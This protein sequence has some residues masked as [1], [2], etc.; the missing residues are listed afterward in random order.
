MPSRLEDD[1]ADEGGSDG[2]RVEVGAAL[3]AVGGVGMEEMAF[4]A[5]A[6]SA[7]VEPGSFHED[8]F[9]VAEM[10]GIEAT[11]HAGEA[12]RLYFRRR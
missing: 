11:D 6:N 8:V 3:E 9:G 4:G 10:T 7:G 2:G 1:A 5:A 12:E